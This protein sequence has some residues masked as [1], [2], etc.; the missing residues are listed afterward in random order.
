MNKNEQFDP[1]VDSWISDLIGALRDPI[2]CH[3][4]N[5]DRPPEKIQSAITL[6][7]LAENLLANKENR[8]PLGT[9]AECAW[10]LSSASLDAPLSSEWVRIYGYCFT[11]LCQFM[12]TE[13][14]DDL[15]QDK[16]NNYEMGLLLGLKQWIYRK[17][18]EARKDKDRAERREQKAQA[19]QQ[20]AI[21]QPP[22]FDF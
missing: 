15:R 1:Q 3:E 18:S 14:P 16:L 7:R 2:I 19:K 21:L 9:D 20:Q 13:I 10:Y 17:R 22:M 6:M 5:L 12:N 4:R 11:K 8:Q